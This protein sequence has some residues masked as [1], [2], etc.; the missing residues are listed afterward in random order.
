MNA[1]VGGTRK[2]KDDIEQTSIQWSV[3]KV[4]TKRIK[5]LGPSGKAE[6]WAELVDSTAEVLTIIFH[7]FA[8][9]RAFVIN[10]FRVAT[11]SYLK[12][13]NQGKFL[14]S[15]FTYLA[16]HTAWKL[17]SGGL[18]KPSGRVLPRYQLSLLAPW[19]LY[20]IGSTLFSM[21]CRK[22]IPKISANPQ[23][24]YILR[25]TCDCRILLPQVPFLFSTS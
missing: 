20:K 23:G 21:L 10:F 25:V 19:Y 13:E 18:Q 17:P 12:L 6:M 2:K 16:V 3:G 9:H 15:P 1:W 8:L 24:P 4:S 22:A 14:C 7:W 5:R 11:V